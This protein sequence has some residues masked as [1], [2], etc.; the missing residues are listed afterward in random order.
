[1]LICK[2]RVEAYYQLGKYKGKIDFLHL[3]R[4]LFLILEAAGDIKDVIQHGFIISTNKKFFN[5]L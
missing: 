3:L 2:H 5:M 1:V 4:L